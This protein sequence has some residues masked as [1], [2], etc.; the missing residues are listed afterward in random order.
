MK[1]YS[2]ANADRYLTDALVCTELFTE[3][4]VEIL[5]RIYFARAFALFS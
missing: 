5:D 2:V 3:M 4:E 1:V